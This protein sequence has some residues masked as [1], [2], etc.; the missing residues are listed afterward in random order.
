MAEPRG[1]NFHC[2]RIDAGEEHSGQEPQHDPLRR[3]VRKPSERSV[4]DGAETG[5]QRKQMTRTDD[6]GKIQQSAEEGSRDESQLHGKRKP[7]G[8]I[9]AE[10]PFLRQCR[11]NRRTAKPKRHG[12]QFG[13]GQQCQRAPAGTWR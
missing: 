7:V 10:M 3:I 4:G 12:Q 13:D 8:G 11:N 2:R 9:R 6:V 5:G 1:Q